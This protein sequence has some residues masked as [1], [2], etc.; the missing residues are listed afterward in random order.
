MAE[1]EEIHRF[2][3]R[4]AWAGDAGGRGA[5]E[6]NGGATSVPI[7]GAPSLGGAGGAANPEEL[8]L[9][10][11]GACFVNTWTLFLKKLGVPYA[12]PAVR[13]L[14]ELGKDPEGGY[15]MRGAVIHARVPGPLLAASRAAIE[16]TLG[17]AERY[18]IIS[19]V[20]RAAMTVRVEIEEV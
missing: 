12:E 3:I 17:L 1:A 9:A 4:A 20:A 7:A 18:C 10:S 2:E 14:G 19:K 16:K 5:V 6:V 8:L 15:R 13:V 11:V